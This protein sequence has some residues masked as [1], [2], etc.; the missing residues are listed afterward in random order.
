MAEAS[1]DDLDLG[2]SLEVVATLVDHARAV[3]G[4]EV[5]DLDAEAETDPDTGAVE[6]EFDEDSLRAAILAL[7]EDEQAALIGL[8]LVGRGDFTPEEWEDAITEGAERDN[9]ADAAEILLAM[10]NF[11][12]LLAEGVAAFGL[13]IEDVER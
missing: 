2:I 11:G 4:T 3:Q 6:D 9:G 5:V 1:E 7:N 10:D 13:S 12:D 8:A